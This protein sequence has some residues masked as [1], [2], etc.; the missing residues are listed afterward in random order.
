MTPSNGR[1]VHYVLKQ[2]RSAGAHRPAMIVNA[3]G[4]N[5]PHVNL[6]VHLDGCNDDGHE[7]GD[8]TLIGHAFSAPRDDSA[9]MPGSWHEPERVP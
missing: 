5:T 6:H 9:T 2:G 3:H 4:G 8:A 1:I 7:F